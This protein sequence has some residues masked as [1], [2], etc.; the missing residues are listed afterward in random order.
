MVACSPGHYHIP[1]RVFISDQRF[2]G[3]GSF[4]LFIILNMRPDISNKSS[5]LAITLLLLVL[6]LFSRNIY[7]IYAAALFILTCLLFDPVA[8]FFHMAWMKLALVLGML[9]ST[10]FPLGLILKLT[11]KNSLL[12]DSRNRTTTFTN[13]NKIFTKADLQNPF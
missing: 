13:R 5:I 6:F 1:G 11:G 7:F 9:S 4:H 2:I 3:I 12:L 10:I 8:A